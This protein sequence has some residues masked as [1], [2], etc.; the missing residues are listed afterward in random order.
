MTAQDFAMHAIEFG[1]ASIPYNIFYASTGAPDLL[2][3]CFSKR[4]ETL[5][6]GAEA[7]AK[8]R[9]ALSR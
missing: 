9:R 6:R 7:L 4:D 2:R 5:D 8:A 3:L 1:V